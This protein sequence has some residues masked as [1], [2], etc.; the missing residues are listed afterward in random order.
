LAQNA[1]VGLTQIQ[2]DYTTHTITTMTTTTLYVTTTNTTIAT[3]IRNS[4]ASLIQR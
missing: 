2:L 1:S 4:L 3:A